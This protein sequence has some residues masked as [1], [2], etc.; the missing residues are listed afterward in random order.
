M[1]IPK[2]K[3]TGAEY[4]AVT[5][6]EKAELEKDPNYRAKYVFR[7]AEGVP[8]VRTARAINVTNETPKTVHVTTTAAKEPVEAKRV[9]REPVEGLDIEQ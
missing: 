3:K 2:N 5:D 9:K 6:A 7:R 4:P 1:W 8:E